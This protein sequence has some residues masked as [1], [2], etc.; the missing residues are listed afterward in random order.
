VKRT[1]KFA[2]GVLA[3]CWVVTSAWLEACVRAGQRVAE[4]P[5]EVRGIVT[6]PST[7]APARSRA[8][9]AAGQPL[10]LA[11]LTFRILEPLV[12]LSHQDVCTLIRSAGGSVSS[13]ALSVPAPPG[14]G[15]LALISLQT[16]QPWSFKAAVEAL[17]LTLVDQLWLLDSVSSY[18]RLPI[19]PYSW[20][21]ITQK[22]VKMQKNKQA[23][24]KLEGRR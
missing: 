8:A 4:E 13:E 11:G 20:E 19:E 18:T 15:T 6:A 16:P 14:A 5:F 3:G 7:L 10:L 9:A 24:E 23:S 1:L 22:T 12:K 2:Q 21:A 17:N